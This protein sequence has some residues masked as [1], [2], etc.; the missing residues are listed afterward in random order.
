[1][2][3]WILYSWARRLTLERDVPELDLS[4]V[5]FRNI[6]ETGYFTSR[7]SLLS[8]YRGSVILLEMWRPPPLLLY[9]QLSSTRFSH[10]QSGERERGSFFSSQEFL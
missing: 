8:L 1:M 10:I 5:V 6:L 3:P 9:V 2:F 7:L 4:I